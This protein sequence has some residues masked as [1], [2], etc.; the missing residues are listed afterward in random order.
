LGDTMGVI[1]G[2][3]SEEL[4]DLEG[5]ERIYFSHR[6]CAGGIVEGIQHYRFAESRQ[7]GEVVA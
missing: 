4:A 7:E 2:N 5:R 6:H 1:V 3:H